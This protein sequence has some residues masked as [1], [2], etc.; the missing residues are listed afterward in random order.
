MTRR[1][2]NVARCPIDHD[3]V[4]TG[5]EDENA[6]IYEKFVHQS[7]QSFW[8][9]ARVCE[10]GKLCDQGYGTVIYSNIVVPEQRMY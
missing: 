4:S 8:M 2:W 1:P 5:N 10:K 9:N 6:F 7:G 3:F